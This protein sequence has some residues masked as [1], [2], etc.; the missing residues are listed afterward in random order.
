LDQRF[1]EAVLVVEDQRDAREMLTEYL[2]FR[3]FTVHTAADGQEAIAVA[4]RLH[5]PIILMDL[6]MPRMDGWEATRRLKADARTRDI[7]IIALSAHSP[8]IDDRRDRNAGWDDFIQ[9]PCNLAS[10]ADRLRD[11]FYRRS[12]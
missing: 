12:H 11:F 8:A 4:E 5:P 3:G 7:T 1:G 10:L 6:M 9:K 2:V